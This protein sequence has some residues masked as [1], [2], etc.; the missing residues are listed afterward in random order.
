MDSVTLAFASAVPVIETDCSLAL[1][2]SLPAT[3]AMVGGLGTSV[4]ISMARVASAET[5]PA[6]S[7][8]VATRVSGPWPMAVMSAAVSV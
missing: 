5:L 3:I 7:E 1:S 2:T 8:T 6:A 4:S